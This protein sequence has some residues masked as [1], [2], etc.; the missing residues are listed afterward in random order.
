MSTE[1]DIKVAGD[2]GNFGERHTSTALDWGYYAH[3]SVYSFA[4]QWA[5]GKQVLDVGCGTAYGSRLMVG[6]KA[7]SVTALDRD[8][9]FVEALKRAE[10]NKGVAFFQCDL[11]SGKIDKKDGSID[12]LICTN[13]L[14]HVAYIDPVI[15][16]FSRILASKGKAILSVP[17]VATV[18]MLKENAKNMFHIN[19]LP[20]FVWESKLKRYFKDVKCMRHWVIADKELSPT[21]I[22][23]SNPKLSDFVFPE[24]K[25]ENDYVSTITAVFVCENPRDEILAKDSEVGFPESWQHL[26]VEAEGRQEVFVELNK[27]V[28]ELTSELVRHINLV[29]ETRRYYKDYIAAKETMT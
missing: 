24:C 22:D 8:K 28:E 10:E 26:R 15:E 3:L 18:G 2:H 17:P 7:R 6:A 16:E 19:N 4:S 20:H 1:S 27:K 11:D 9:E 21:T 12:L 29:N 13:V 14:E 5:S 23:F 25:T